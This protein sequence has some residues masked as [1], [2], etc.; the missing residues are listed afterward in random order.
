MIG[1]ADT[2]NNHKKLAPVANGRTSNHLQEPFG[3]GFFWI[4]ENILRRAFFIVLEYERRLFIFNLT[5]DS[6]LKELYGHSLMR[7]RELNMVGVLLIY[8]ANFLPFPLAI[9][10]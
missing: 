2:S 10:R 6:F 5:E 3:A 7:R 9:E 4:A 8:L 1:N